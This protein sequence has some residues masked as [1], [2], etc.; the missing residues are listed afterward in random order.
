VILQESEKQEE[1]EVDGKLRHLRTTFYYPVLELEEE[2]KN[3]VQQ[4]RNI[5]D[6]QIRQN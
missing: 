6:M 5:L 2:G 3:T 1:S 4:L